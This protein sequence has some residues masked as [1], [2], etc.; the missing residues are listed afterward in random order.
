MFLAHRLLSRHRPGRQFAAVGSVR[1][2]S[3]PSSAAVHSSIREA[4]I[5]IR[6]SLSLINQGERVKVAEDQ[7]KQLTDELAVSLFF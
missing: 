4:F 2:V 3:A 6:N 5:D 7:V 1:Y